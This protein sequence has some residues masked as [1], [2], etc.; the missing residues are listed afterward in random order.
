MLQLILR[1]IWQ[2][3]TTDDRFQTYDRKNQQNSSPGSQRFIFPAMLAVSWTNFAGPF[4]DREQGKNTLLRDAASFTYQ[5]LLKR[6]IKKQCSEYTAS[7]KIFPLSLYSRLQKQNG[8]KT[9]SI[10]EA[11]FIL[12]KTIQNPSGI[13]KSPL[14]TR[15]AFSCKKVIECCNAGAPHMVKGRKVKDVPSNVALKKSD[16]MLD[17]VVQKPGVHCFI[18]GS[19]LHGSV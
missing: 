5:S 1:L 7:E 12:H 3:R 2:N 11:L 8:S 19:L 13:C 9:L 6:M 18:A 17:V 4:F 14:W 15:Y 10:S 16:G